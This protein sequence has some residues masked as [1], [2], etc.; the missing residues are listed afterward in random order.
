[1][2][3]SRRTT[4]RIALRAA[5][6]GKLEQGWLYLPTSE[7]P[8]PD[9]P[10]LLVDPGPDDDPEA[11]ALER[12]FPTEGLDTA[13]IE[14]TAKCACLFRNPPTD[15]LLLE[16]FVYY[17]RFD[18]WL[19]FPGAPDP[20]PREETKKRL[21]REFFE[22]L[23]EERRGET[24]RSQGCERGAIHQSVF[25]RVHHYEMIKGEPC[26]FLD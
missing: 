5:A 26:P 4:M 25:C 16:S 23:G 12:G 3:V 17:W 21:D 15:A 6:A 20:P 14:D 22:A 19:P 7:K 18:A 10:C 11:I 13:T 2:A 9:T 24:C 1:M 8:T